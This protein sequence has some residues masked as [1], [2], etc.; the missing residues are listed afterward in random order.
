MSRL[1]GWFRSSAKPD[2]AS[3][4][5]SDSDSSRDK[6][7]KEMEDIDDAM[8]SSGL[9]MNDDIDG[10]WEKLQTGDSSFHQLGL[11]VTIFMR[12][13][14]GFEKEVMAET[15]AK[16]D[17]CEARAWTDYKKA[18]RHGKARAGSKLYPP[19]TEYELV[20][21]ETQLMGAVVGVLHESLIEAMK[22]FYK[23]R[24]AFLTL[25]AIIAAE[26][27]ALKE[28]N[29]SQFDLASKIIDDKS[30]DSSDSSG[31]QT[32]SNP[33]DSSTTVTS[34]EGTVDGEKT[35]DEAPLQAKSKPVTS[36]T[37][38]LDNPLDIFVHS[39]ANMCFGI[40]LLLLTL[41][42][43]AFSRILSIVGFSGDRERGVRMLWRSIAYNN[44]N[45]AI[46]AMA[47][48]AYYNG[49]L[50]VVDILPDE[51]DYDEHADV[52]GPPRKK[53][54]ELLATMRQRYP[55]SRL[56]RVEEARQYANEQQLPKAVELLTTGEESKMKQVAAVN[57]FEL[58]ISY[59][60]VQNWDGM[61]DAFLRCLEVNDWSPALYYYMAG[62]ASLELYRDAVHSGDEDEARR[63]K[64]K[65][66]EFFGKA[67]SVVGKKKFMARQLP[68]DT[69]VHRKIQKWE[70]RAKAAGVDLADAIGPSPALEMAYLWNGPKRM[71]PVELERAMANLKWERCTAKEEVLEAI[72]NEVDEM[73]IWALLNGTLLKRMGKYDEARAVLQEHILKRDRYTFKG[74]T[75]DDYVPPAA[76][77]ELAS[78][79]WAECC[80]PPEG[81][82]EEI[83]AFRRQ[84]FDD[85]Q[86][87]LDIVKTWEVYLMDA[88]I[89]MRVQSG[90]E[91]LAWFKK[92]MAYN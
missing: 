84:K 24:K 74:P 26:E 72:K 71:G 19:G 69:Y 80:N 22:G 7:A 67:P 41:V 52:V 75:K 16:L 76:N 6:V 27:K 53:C 43:P 47:L 58:S 65:A 4:T 3:A 73:G 25:D 68:I 48:L 92:K 11:A 23:L 44:V 1:A 85:C 14:L 36:D 55:N 90:L 59:M 9:I 88:R 30:G 28:M 60:F 87:Q 64:V 49:M 79:A 39:G 91:T 77:Y 17:E 70:E 63:Q 35:A 38:V 18:Q 20:R 56:W 34:T 10:A 46:A 54:D 15:T 66:H 21:A 13:V 12:S 5:G 83:A 62:S 61:R 31:V 50:G 8:N 89:G 2:D 33:T 37:M 86:K 40:L 81:T 29:D 42:P 57:N 78:I 32:P 45:G 51:K 82:V